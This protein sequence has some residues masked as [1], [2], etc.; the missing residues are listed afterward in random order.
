MVLGLEYATKLVAAAVES[1]DEVEDSFS[2]G[3][4]DQ[5][6]HVDLPPPE[7]KS[8]VDRAMQTATIDRGHRVG[9]FHNYYTFHP[10]ANRLSV[11]DECGLLDV[12]AERLLDRREG[13]D[14]DNSNNK[15]GVQFGGRRELSVTVASD[16]SAEGG[17]NV[18]S[19]KKQR[20]DNAS[21]PPSSHQWYY[22]DLGCNEGDLTVELSD[23]ILRQCRKLQDMSDEKNI[24][25]DT[26]G[27]TMQMKCLG[28]DIDGVLIQ[29]ANDKYEDTAPD[30]QKHVGV[31]ASFEVC[32]LCDETMHL[33]RYRSFLD[34]SS[35]KRF[36]LTTLFSTTM[37]IHIHAGDEGLRNFLQRTCDNTDMILV[38]PQPSKC[39]R[40]ANTRLR[41]MNQPELDS[42]TSQSL[43][44]R[45]NIENEVERIITECGF[46]RVSNT[47]SPEESEASESGV[48]KE[49]KRTAW[50]RQL[51]LYAKV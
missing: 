1:R 37:W 2:Q 18:S 7:G 41:R 32:N 31:D 34:T 17:A 9:N 35:R 21:T 10:P 47:C 23:S 15:P 4:S 16:A 42:V 40:Q 5:L 51:Q 44:M 22:C 19:R 33:S 48:I 12:I 27:A 45:N 20:T 50:Q 14:A 3:M 13:M 6:L 49:T 38:E 43:R 11:L 25:S 24:G 8:A 36:D 46:Q 30:D 26:I 29:R 39:Y 28:L